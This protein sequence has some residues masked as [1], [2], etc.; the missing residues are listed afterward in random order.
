MTLT[1]NIT[2]TG[3]EPRHRM[4]QVSLETGRE[5]SLLSSASTCPCGP[6]WG[7]RSQ[8]CS[9]AHP[10]LG[11]EPR[12]A[13]PVCQADCS[14][15]FPGLKISISMISL[16]LPEAAPAGSGKKTRKGKIAR[17]RV[18]N[19]G[20]DVRIRLLWIRIWDGGTELRTRFQS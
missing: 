13:Q 1:Q 6:S 11:A 18:W 5:S 3:G 12:A 16:P 9:T 2:L 15:S 8:G 19:G 7:R 10:V 20:R 14:P 17:I 4:G